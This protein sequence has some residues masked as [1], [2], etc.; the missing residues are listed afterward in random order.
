MIKNISIPVL[1]ICMILYSLPAW[2]RTPVDQVAGIHHTATEMGRIGDTMPARQED[3]L[4][5][6]LRK[7]FKN[8]PKIYIS[9]SEMKVKALMAYVARTTKYEFVF[10]N[11]DS[12]LAGNV[13]AD[14]HIPLENLLTILFYKNSEDIE[15]RG[16]TVFIS[17][18]N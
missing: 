3:S 18:K 1:V 8:V 15:V 4:R 6:V 11:I 13:D 2:S 9:C 12:L 17:R 7:H 14:I 5:E 16:H 10:K